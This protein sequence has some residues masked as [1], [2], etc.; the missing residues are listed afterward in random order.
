MN[1]VRWCTIKQFNMKNISL[2]CDHVRGFDCDATNLRELHICTV[3]DDSN[4]ISNVVRNLSA[5]LDRAGK[6]FLFCVK[7][8]HVVKVH[9]C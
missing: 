5:H 3:V 6:L 9:D 2:A 1:K 8:E 4:N 7:V